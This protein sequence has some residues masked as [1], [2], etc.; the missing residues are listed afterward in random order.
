M[1]SSGF[2]EVR[3][4]A[5]ASAK[6]EVVP[7]SRGFSMRWW[8]A[9]AFAGVAAL[10]AVAVVAVMNSRS[11]SA[12]RAHGAD[13]AVGG[14]VAAAEDLKG[15]PTRAA[16]QA[17]AVRI[18]ENRQVAVFVLDAK[19]RLLTARVSH[20]ESWAALP[21]HL[22]AVRTALG[23]QRFIGGSR[24]GSALTVALHVHGG[25]GAMVVTFTLRP[26]LAAQLGIVRNEGPRSALVAF[27]LA[28][29]AGLLIAVLISRRLAGI[30]RRAHAIGAGDFSEQPVDGFPDEVGSLSRSIDG[31]RRQLAEYFRALEEERHRL[32]RLLGRLTDAVILVDRDLT[33]EFVNDQGRDYVT[34]ARR[35]DGLALADFAAELFTSEAPIQQKTTLSDG[36]VLMISGIPPAVDTD[37]AILVVTDETERERNEGLQREFATNAAHELRTPL[38]AIVTAIEMLQTGAKE[39]VAERDEFLGLIERE[40]ARLT[41][42]TRALL[43]VARSEWG[44]EAVVA[45]GVW[46]RAV[47]DDLAERIPLQPGVA[48]VVDCPSDL[49]LAANADLIEQALLTLAMNAA[50]HTTAGTITFRGFEDDAGAVIEISDTGSGI[51]YRE[52][53]RIF[54]RFYRAGRAGSGFGLGLSIARETVRVLGGEITLESQPGVGTVVRIRVPLLSVREAA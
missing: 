48:A 47:L 11:E 45:T 46:L 7:K 42:L 9:A 15:A 51:P 27:A 30:A 37:A 39:N 34:P 25:V 31:M 29:A 52:Q 53:P 43:L 10:T 8:L 12:L 32:E 17:R 50:E 6:M 24:D 3:V 40:S 13:L 2:L 35:L 49:L 5:D 1:D 19:G 22:E 38:A 21:H 36:R 18:A 23:G 16:L 14:T 4:S 44:D 54:D 28:A 26:E 20:G 41:R 33:V